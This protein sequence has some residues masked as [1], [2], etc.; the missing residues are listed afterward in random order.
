MPLQLNDKDVTAD[1]AELHSALIV[2]CNMCPAVT[3][4]VR[5]EKPFM[6]CFKSLLKS[7]PFQQ[8][9]R[10]LQSRLRAKGVRTKVFQSH[11]YHHWFMCMWTTGQRNRLKRVARQYDAVIVL[12][13][14]SATETVRH[15][16]GTTRCKVIEGMEVVG[17]MN[18]RMKFHW[19]GNIHFE[20]CEMI[21]LSQPQTR[22]DM[23]TPN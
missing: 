23:S 12:G 8:H 13:C 2:P 11:L 22:A 14:D 20:H 15:L 18:A 5:E 19:P 1:V 4:A 17:I 10:M 7:T 6:Q 21:P 3:V 16:V 9:I